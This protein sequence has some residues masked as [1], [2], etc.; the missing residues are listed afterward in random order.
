MS[1]LGQLCAANICRV[2][3]IV[4][5]SVD[6][7]GEAIYNSAMKLYQS[8]IENHV[9]ETSFALKCVNYCLLSFV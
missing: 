9:S 4:F 5:H 6:D 3:G 1:I 8:Q 2:V 7:K